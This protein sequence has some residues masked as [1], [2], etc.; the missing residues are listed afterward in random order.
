MN[1]IEEKQTK[2]Q[3]QVFRHIVEKNH[4]DWKYSFEVQLGEV[5]NRHTIKVRGDDLEEVIADL[6]KAKAVAK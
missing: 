6:K 3:N 5:G 1:Q 4:D 2:K